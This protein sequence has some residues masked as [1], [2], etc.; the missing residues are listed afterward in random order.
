[1]AYTPEEEQELNEI[2]AWWKENYKVL[3]ASIVVAFAGV[4]GWNYWQSYQANKI[5]QTSVFYEQAIYSSQD[6]A[7]KSAQIDQFVQAH[8]K[9]S[10]AVLALLEKAKLEVEKEEFAQA[11]QSLKQALAQSSD[12]TLSSISALR[13]ASV[14]FQQQAFDAALESLQLVKEASWDSRK[15]LLTGDILLAKGDKIA[16][17]A[18]YEQALQNAS[19]LEAQWLQVRLNNL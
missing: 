14:Q 6:F 16:A 1:M 15:S 13:L 18:S 2:K 10:Y 8:N 5:Q 3:I 11:E 12:Q 4:F 7:T 17:K 9:T 19:A